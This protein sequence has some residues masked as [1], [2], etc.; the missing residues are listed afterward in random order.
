MKDLIVMKFG[1]S[2][3]RSI[4]GIKNAARLVSS[5][6]AQKKNIVVVVSPMGETTNELMSLSQQITS[7]PNEREF[8]L[9]MSAGK[10]ISAALMAIS[11]QA[12]GHQTCSFNSLRLKSRD[13]M[14]EYGRMQKTDTASLVASLKR[15]FIPVVAGFQATTAGGK[16]I[17]SGQGDAD[18]TAIVL[19][20]I[21]KAERCDFYI[22][23]DGIYSADPLL[24]KDAVKLDRIAFLEMYELSKNRSISL[25]PMAVRVAYDKSVPIQVRSALHPT[26]EGTLVVPNFSQSRLFTGLSLRTDVSCVEINSEK[27]DL[28]SDRK[29]RSFRKRRL[30][31]K[32]Q[33]MELFSEADIR[34]EMVSPG[35]PNPFRLIVMVNESDT[36]RAMD[37]VNT[38]APTKRQVCVDSNVACIT[39]VAAEITANHQATA[40]ST[41]SAQNIPVIAINMSQRKLTLIVPRQ[42][43]T[44]A[45]KILHARF[46]ELSNAAA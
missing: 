44:T 37:A 7:V 3:L 42:F 11:L 29:L 1:E 41:L 14:I 10:Q 38:A 24:V 34:A 23:A 46:L 13:Q 28:G 35:R 6:A 16:I 12:L 22:D 45:L 40:L 39:L 9:L 21:F 5:Q 27:L 26:E 31:T 32:R 33:L 8:D 18:L 15:G 19:A 17:M 43:G 2:C 20:A 25:D 30:Q 36:I 4:D